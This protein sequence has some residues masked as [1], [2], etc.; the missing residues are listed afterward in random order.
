MLRNRKYLTWIMGVSVFALLAFSTVGCEMVAA[1]DW[2]GRDWQRHEGIRPSDFEHGR[3][4][5]ELP[6]GLAVNVRLEQEIST[7]FDRPG[8]TFRV[9]LLQPLERDGYLIAPAGSEAIGQIVYARR[10]GRFRGRASMSFDLTQLFVGDSTY[11]FP[12]HA[13]RV[14][15]EGERREDTGRIAGGAILGAIIG[16]IVHGGEGA[17]TGAL[18]GGGT[19]AGYDFLTRGDAVQFGPGTRFVFRLEN[20]VVLPAYRSRH[21]EF[22]GRYHEGHHDRIR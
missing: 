12:T 7:R 22:Y 21:A 17:A 8:D 14:R 19:G 15:A 6:A 3:E 2:R 20:P 13:I 10:A 16:G 18:I 4:S 1:Q 11:D 9:R 5:I